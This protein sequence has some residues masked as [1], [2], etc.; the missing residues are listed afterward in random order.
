MRIGD[1]ET[2]WVDVSCIN[3]NFWCCLISFYHKDPSRIWH[4]S[5]LRSRNLMKL[6][7]FAFWMYL[8]DVMMLDDDDD[9]DDVIKPG[10]V[11]FIMLKR[12]GHVLA[13]AGTSC[14]V[15][16]TW[17]QHES[18]LTYPWILRFPLWKANRRQMDRGKSN[19]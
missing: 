19:F 10:S 18:H 15:A 1:D 6:H 7:L 13:K 8:D 3:C 11:S 12:F 5:G 4:D 9:D 2:N 17:V 14:L 16:G